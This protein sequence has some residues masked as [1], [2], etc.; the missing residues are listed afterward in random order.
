MTITTWIKRVM[1][2][3]NSGSRLIV[4]LVCAAFLLAGCFEGCTTTTTPTGGDGSFS[5]QYNQ[6]NTIPNTGGADTWTK[7]PI[8]WEG[9]RDLGV[10]DQQTVKDI[11]HIEDSWEGYPSQGWYK[12]TLVSNLNPGSWTL[13]ATVNGNLLVCQSKIELTSGSIV[14]VNF[15]TSKDSGAFTGCT[16]N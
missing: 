8:V 14:T 7:I 4:T 2:I 3:K 11:F 13:S 9:V 5:L 10:E 12:N 6:S 16:H 1:L 15:N